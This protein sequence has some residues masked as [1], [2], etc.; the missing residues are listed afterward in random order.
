MIYLNKVKVYTS[1]VIEGV[2]KNDDH[3]WFE[4][5]KPQLL[6]GD[7]RIEFYNKPKMSRKVQSDCFVLFYKFKGSRLK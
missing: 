5:P 1:A 6:G 7:I 4:L 3:I 2:K